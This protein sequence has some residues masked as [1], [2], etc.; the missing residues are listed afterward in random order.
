MTNRRDFLRTISAASLAL[1]MPSIAFA[2]AN[3]D[4]RFVFI[5]QRG[6][7]DGLNIVVPYAES[8]YSALRK[9][10]AVDIK[11]ADKLDGMFG[12]NPALAETKK[13]Y[14]VGQAMFVHAVASPYRARSHFD[15]Q[16][17]LETGGTSP[18]QLKDGW[19]NRLLAQLP[20]A[21]G[22]AIAFSSTVPMALRGVLN[23]A[24]YA[25]SG[26]PEA[27]DDLLIRVSKLYE[28]DMQLHQA[29]KAAMQA[30]ML[31]EGTTKKQNPTAIGKLA[32]SFLKQANGP[33]IAMIETGGWDTHNAQNNRL[34]RQLKS[35]DATIASLKTNLGT[36]WQDTTVVVCTEFGRT[37]A[38]NGTAGT[39]HGTGAVAM[40]Y[41]GSLKGG[42]VMADWPG[43]KQSD[44]YQERDLKPTMG[45]DSLITSILGEKYG[46][47]SHK[48]ADSLF[49]TSPI[50]KPFSGFYRASTR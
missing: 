6:A 49:P 48:L 18:Y 19:M 24:S 12:L 43:L 7:A 9:S 1:T 2:K 38:V 42:R 22:E 41:G 4:K 21:Q 28:E 40:I 10:I 3:T 26:L 8:A 45:L 32:A 44:L 15:G 23:V 39:D 47:D 46:L 27:P 14:D 50:V 30:E 5:M 33:R 11:Q 35:L 20:E 16:N 29:W 31:A 13:M 36:V 37:A 25:P 17:V 34:T